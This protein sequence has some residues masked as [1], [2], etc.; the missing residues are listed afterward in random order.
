MQVSHRLPDRDPVR[1]EHLIR[2]VRPAERPEQRDALGRRDR[3]VRAGP[4]GV[5][6]H[7]G[8]GVR[9]RDPT[10]AVELAEVEPSGAGNR[11]ESADARHRLR[12]GGQPGGQPLQLRPGPRVA[13]QLALG[14]PRRAAS[15]STASSSGPTGSRES[16]C[17]R[18]TARATRVPS[19]SS[20]DSS[21]DRTG[22]CPGVIAP[23]SPRAAAP[24]PAQRPITRPDSP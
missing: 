8:L 6:L 5:H 3:P 9:E 1:R 19:G 16:G 7:L 20:P 24:E 18:Q 13:D 15:V 21:A 12:V 23:V 11:L 4:A 14:R 17:A 10:R 22:T 2:D